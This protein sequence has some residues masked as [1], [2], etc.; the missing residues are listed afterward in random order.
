MTLPRFNRRPA[1]TPHPIE[2]LQ[3]PVADFTY[4]VVDSQEVQFT[5][6]AFDPDGTVVKHEW[7]FGET[8]TP[9]VAKFAAVPTTGL[10]I[11]FTDQSTA[12]A[13][14]TITAW[15]WTFGD[16][17]TSTQQH[18]LKTYTA[19]GN[20]NVRLT[21][22]DSAGLQST[23]VQQTIAM[24]TRRKRLGCWNLWVGDSWEPTGTDILGI[25][26][27]ASNS[28]AF[29]D[30]L[31]FC[32][33]NGKQI[34]PNLTPNEAAVLDANGNWNLNQWKAYFNESVAL[35]QLIAEAVADGVMIGA[36]L[37]DEPFNTRWGTTFRNHPKGGK[38][39]VDEMA[40]H[41]HSI[42][43][44]LP[45]G[46]TLDWD[47]WG[48][49]KFYEMD[50]QQCQYT[51]R[52]GTI[53]DFR[54]GGLALKAFQ[55]GKL[56][57][58]LNVLNGGIQ[59]KN[60]GDTCPLPETLGNGTRDGQCRMTAAQLESWGI[61]LGTVSDSHLAFWRY[62]QSYFQRSDVQTA[63][64]NIVAAIGVQAQVS[65]KSTPRPGRPA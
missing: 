64:A 62:E 43:P 6:T 25:A 44:T 50:F 41:A 8:P 21:V 51:H 29:P 11:Q 31:A 26:V 39:L 40:V 63:L 18:P 59:A 56:A 20:Y 58:A 4:E 9:P 52:Q 5:S 19:T 27:G 13:P 37:I 7:H 32:R 49:E 45:V 48:D 46:V 47:L 16:G 10:S 55:G 15:A 36:I 53:T 61:T 2:V 17:S 3:P 30:R 33:A 14:N 1:G 28:A 24:N 42:H 60:F 65:L 35:K 38:W 54:D 57:F 34:M 22:T 23:P 12:T